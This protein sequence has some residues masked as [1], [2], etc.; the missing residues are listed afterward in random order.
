[1]YIDIPISIFHISVFR[2]NINHTYYTFKNIVAANQID[3]TSASKRTPIYHIYIKK[4][5][6]IITGRLRISE[7]SPG[8]LVAKTK[9]L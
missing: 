5:F 8:N 7:F 1:M 9:D 3:A 4:S 6:L 2:I